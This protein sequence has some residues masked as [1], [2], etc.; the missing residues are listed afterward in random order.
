MP[1]AFYDDDNTVP[2]PGTFYYCGRRGGRECWKGV[3]LLCHYLERKMMTLSVLIPT[4]SLSLRNFAIPGRKGIMG[5]GDIYLP[6][7]IHAYAY[8]YFFLP[9]ASPSQF[10]RENILCSTYI[11]LMQKTH[12]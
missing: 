12:M 9:T 10:M 7:P 4:P 2:W 8:L 5:R 6:M 1:V 11:Y 3:C